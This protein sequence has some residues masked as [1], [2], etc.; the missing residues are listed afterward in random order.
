MLFRSQAIHDEMMACHDL[1]TCDDHKN[2]DY[3]R[4][5]KKDGHSHALNMYDF[6][7]H[8]LTMPRRGLEEPGGNMS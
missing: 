6:H 7:I 4:A 3:G 1:T 2:M 8:F 5:E